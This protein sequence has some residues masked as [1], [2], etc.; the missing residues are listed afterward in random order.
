[1]YKVLF[2]A[3][4]IG[5]CG[6]GISSGY[7][8]GITCGYGGARSCDVHA[9]SVLFI[10]SDEPLMREV[11]GLSCVL[12]VLDELSIGVGF[13]VPLLVTVHMYGQKFTV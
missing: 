6:C 1:M 2:V 10:G 4:I 5:R 9:L 8:S 11:A 12:L 7:N 13:V 3:R